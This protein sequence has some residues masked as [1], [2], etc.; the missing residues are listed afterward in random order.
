[1]TRFPV[2]ALAAALAVAALAACDDSGSAPPPAPAYLGA[3]VAPNPTMV[4]AAVV[5]VEAERFDSAWVRVLDPV[6]DAT[7]RTPAVAFAPGATVARI[8][9]LGLAPDRAF[10]LEVVLAADDVAEAV[11]TLT[12]TAGALPAWIPA[13]TAVAT[14]TPAP[15]YVVLSFPDGGVIVDNEAT[16]RWYHHSPNGN[17]NAFTAHADGRFTILLAADMVDD[18]ILL[19]REGA[20]V[21]T[22]A[23][24][25]GF[26]TRFHDV[27]ILADGTAWLLCDDTRTMDLSGVGGV[28]DAQVTGTV[29][30]RRD[31]A[32]AVTFTWNAFDHFAITDLPVAD[33]GGA[34]VNFTHGNALD[35]D[36][37]GN[38]LASFR[39]LNEVTKIDLATGDVLWR[40]GGLANQFTIVGDTKGSFARQH[41]LRAAGPG[42]IQFLDNGNEAPSR[43]VR[44]LM[45]PDAGT[46]TLDWA[47][48]DA[49][50]THTLIGGGTDVHGPTGHGI[51]SF[52][53]EGR[54][55]EG[56]ADGA[57]VWEL[58]GIDGTYVFRIQRIPSIY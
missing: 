31:P 58:A 7:A 40:F 29:I 34:A 1:M 30:Q 24:A 49:P 12:Y 10:G 15:G 5:T 48:V 52:G 4:V 39:S 46:A 11:D 36:T 8:P 41:G 42:V 27:R 2:P 13:M 16:V 51:V 14:G 38:L 28:A 55:V 35:F 19:D 54:V 32:G 18:F 20:E 22:L 45:D 33:R 44:Y 26:R 53:T 3:E 9:V 56:D 47:L 37:D 17:L 6:D 50:E 25:G 57:R 23:C 21:G 43:M